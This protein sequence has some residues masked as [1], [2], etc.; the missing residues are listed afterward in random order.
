MEDYDF[1]RPSRPERIAEILETQGR[2]LPGQCH[3]WNGRSPQDGH[4]VEVTTVFRNEVD[5]SESRRSR[6]P[7]TSR[8]I[9]PGATSR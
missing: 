4:T 7:T 3:F 6:F 9:S 8:P 2:R 1:T 5:D